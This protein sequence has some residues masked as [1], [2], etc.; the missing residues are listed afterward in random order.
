M[1]RSDVDDE[2]DRLYRPKAHKEDD[3]RIKKLMA[4][5]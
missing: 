3:E 2:I 4:E 5:H 1:L